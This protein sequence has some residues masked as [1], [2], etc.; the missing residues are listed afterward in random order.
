MSRPLPIRRG[1]T[2]QRAKE[3]RRDL[4]PAE[5]L[6]WSVIRA[7]RLA[8]LRFRRQHPIGPY[9]ADFYCHEVKLI[10][11]LDGESHEYRINH[12]LE[13]TRYLKALELRVFRVPN[14]EVLTNLEGVAL[15]ILRAAGINI[16][17]WQAECEQEFLAHCQDCLQRIKTAPVGT[18]STRSWTP[19]P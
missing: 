9:I 2:L 7:D 4:T 18:S 17:S 12:D 14:E 11:E 16:E 10:V 13:R 3:L 15:R 5:Q 8:G 1:K 19:S 6:L